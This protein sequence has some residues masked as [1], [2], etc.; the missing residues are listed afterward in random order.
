LLRSHVVYERSPEF[1]S[2][3]TAALFGAPATPHVG[4][5]ARVKDRAMGWGE[6]LLGPVALILAIVIG[7]SFVAM[8][9][10]LPAYLVAWPFR[11]AGAETI[12]L[13][14][15]NGVAVFTLFGLTA[16]MLTRAWGHCKDAR[17]VCER[18]CGRSR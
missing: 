14:V 16:S 18:A 10:L 8:T 17:Q 6:N 2:V 3:L 4:R 13:R 5:L 15:Q 12:G 9:V 7:L 11:L 1:L